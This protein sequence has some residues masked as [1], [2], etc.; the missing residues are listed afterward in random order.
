MTD[1]TPGPWETRKEGDLGATFENHVPIEACG[2]HI[3]SAMDY[4]GWEHLEVTRPDAEANARLI[5][6]APDLKRDLR[7]LVTWLREHEDMLSVHDAGIGDGWE[8]LLSCA[9]ESIAKAEG[10]ADA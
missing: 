3:A 7:S 6:A 4:P 5:A 10:R 9:E 2:V 1:H 8:A